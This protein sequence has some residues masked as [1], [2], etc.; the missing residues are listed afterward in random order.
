MP[1]GAML[2]KGE[3]YVVSGPWSLFVLLQPQ[4]ILHVLEPGL[5]GHQGSG[6]SAWPGSGHGR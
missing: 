1:N 6:G 4:D 3:S 2:V 5:L